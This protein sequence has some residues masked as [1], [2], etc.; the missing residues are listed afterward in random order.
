MSAS[1]NKENSRQYLVKVFNNISKHNFQIL[2]V[3]LGNFITVSEPCKPI[4]YSSRHYQEL[5]K[6]FSLICFVI[7]NYSKIV[8]L[9]KKRIFSDQM[10]LRI[11]DVI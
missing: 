10:I 5:A 4:I 8:K 6:T 2:L 9:C 1:Y 3:V 11:Y 7:F